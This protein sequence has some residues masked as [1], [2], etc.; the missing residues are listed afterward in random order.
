MATRRA[1]AS[2]LFSE[3]MLQ[4]LVDL[5]ARIR[6][7]RTHRRWRLV[8]M[9][10]K[11]GFSRNTIES[12]ERGEPGTSIAAYFHILW[13]MGLDRELELVADPGLDQN[14]MAL[15]ISS[16]DKR[17]RPAQKVDNDF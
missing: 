6:V 16:L 2:G 14:G 17:V 13:I 9:V 4:R 7:A 1:P 8:D 11:S 3:D 12:V 5:G 15:Q 10:N